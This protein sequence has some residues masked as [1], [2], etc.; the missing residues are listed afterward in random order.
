MK[1]IEILL[2][3]VR[4]RSPLVSMAG[5]PLLTRAPR[6]ARMLALAHKLDGLVRSNAVRDYTELARLGGIS[7]SRLFQIL[8]FLNLSPAIQE[9][10]LF[11]TAAEARLPY[12]RDVR[13][14]ARESN[15]SR[16]QALF[17]RLRAKA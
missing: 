13:V 2:P 1:T 3:R 17:S 12:E 6:I 11:L 4:E 7:K 5:L 9:E 10:I 8:V 15:W 16:Q 14:I